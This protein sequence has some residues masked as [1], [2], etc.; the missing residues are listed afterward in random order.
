MMRFMENDQAPD[1]DGYLDFKT[2]IENGNT[3]LK[4]RAAAEFRQQRE[5]HPDRLTTKLARY[6]D[7]HIIEELSDNL[8]RYDP[9]DIF[10]DGEKRLAFIRDRIIRQQATKRINRLLDAWD[11]DR[12]VSD[13]SHIELYE[14]DLRDAIEK[15]QSANPGE[16]QTQSWFH[17]KRDMDSRY[18][19]FQMGLKAHLDRAI[20]KVVEYARAREARAVL[21]QYEAEQKLKQME[22]RNRERDR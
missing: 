18:L 22:Q 13:M 8:L 4:S 12:S 5:L 10:H 3:E 16:K 19:N 9:N 6:M 2:S 1:R 20:D 14:Y 17:A 11:N 21:E 15:R 7:M